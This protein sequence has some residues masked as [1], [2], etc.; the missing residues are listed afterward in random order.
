MI[1]RLLIS[2]T[3]TCIQTIMH[4]ISTKSKSVIL[5]LVYI[6]VPDF[7]ELDQHKKMTNHTSVSYLL[8]THSTKKL[9][10]I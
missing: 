6:Q 1:Q 5:T 3:F 7:F 4:C 9:S 10:Y 2:T 8:M